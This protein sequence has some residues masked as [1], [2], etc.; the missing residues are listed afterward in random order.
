M[1]SLRWTWIHVFPGAGTRGPLFRLGTRSEITLIEL[2][3]AD[4]AGG[5]D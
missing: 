3:G 5:H 2:R 1:A 4:A